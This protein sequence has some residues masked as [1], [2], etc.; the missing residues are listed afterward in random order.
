MLNWSLLQLPCQ[1]VEK[2]A[3]V[4]PGRSKCSLPDENLYPRF[5]AYS[6]T[7]LGTELKNA[8]SPPPSRAWGRGP[9]TNAVW[10]QSFENQVSGSLS[11]LPVCEYFA[12]SADHC[13]DYYFVF[14]SLSFA[15]IY[16]FPDVASLVDFLYCLVCL[17]EILLDKKIKT[18]KKFRVVTAPGLK[19]RVVSRPRLAGSVFCLGFFCRAR[20]PAPFSWRPALLKKLKW[21]P[22]LLTIF[23]FFFKVT[24]GF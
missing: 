10:Q 16:P 22:V 3:D 23:F 17:R 19:F 5:K 24:H 11:T 21:R 7:L 9:E 4:S 2:C 1:S 13:L 6:I 12:M 15:C 14:L 18:W 8:V 20:R